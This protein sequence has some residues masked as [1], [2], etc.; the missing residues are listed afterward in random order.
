MGI[1]SCSI[2]VPSF[3]HSQLWRDTCS[4]WIYGYGASD[5]HTWVTDKRRLITALH[6]MQGGLVMI[7]LSV[8]PS[9]RR[10][11]CPSL[12]RMICDKTKETC[13]H[14][15]IPHEESFILVLWPEECLVNHTNFTSIVTKCIC[16]FCHIGIITCNAYISIFQSWYRRMA[17]LIWPSVIEVVL[18]WRMMC[19][20]ITQ[21]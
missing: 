13:A 5:R 16:A 14:I 12:K 18:W 15:L 2:P 1:C 11:V 6:W 7:K 4:S 9:V 8:R 19:C 21:R 3:P 20:I 17:V 10:S